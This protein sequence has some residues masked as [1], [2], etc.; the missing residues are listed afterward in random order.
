MT[1]EQQ[2][3]VDGYHERVIALMLKSKQAQRYNNWTEEC[4]IA[5]EIEKI[6]NERR[7]YE[8]DVKSQGQE[9][10]EEPR[11]IPEAEEGNEPIETE[12]EVQS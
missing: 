2:K 3:I 5:T 1:R 8:R 4:R 10:R 12:T 6:E 11:G 7:T 9:K